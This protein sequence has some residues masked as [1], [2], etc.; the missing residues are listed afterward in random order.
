M[1]SQGWVHVNFPPEFRDVRALA[2][3][4]GWRVKEDGA[5]FLVCTNETYHRT[6]PHLLVAARLADRKNAGDAAAYERFSRW[7]PQDRYDT[8]T[9]LAEVMAEVGEHQRAATSE[10]I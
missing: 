1:S 3:Q 2:E 9:P 6:A 7:A 8:G 5:G 4:C 10:R